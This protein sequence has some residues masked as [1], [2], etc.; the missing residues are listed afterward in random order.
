MVKRM[1]KYAVLDWDNTLRK[2]FTIKAWMEYLYTKKIICNELYSSFLEQLGLY[3]NHMLSYYKLS[4][5]TTTLYSKAIEGKKAVDIEDAGRDFCIYDRAVFPFVSSLLYNLHKNNTRV[6]VISG[7]P[8]LLLEQYSA[9][10]G[11]DEVYGLVVGVKEGY[12]TGIVER[13]YGANKSEIM[14]EICAEKGENPI[15]ALGDSI[16][17]EPLIN[18]AKFGCYIDKD[19]GAI[20]MDEKVIGFISSACEA[21][22]KLGVFNS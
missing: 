7:T 9:L 6:I 11:I 15:F 5:N 16:A 17:D 2:G 1:I 19:T 10:L 18:A 3:E 12:Y 21:I 14:K 22:E 8:Q 20:S 13:D 4:E